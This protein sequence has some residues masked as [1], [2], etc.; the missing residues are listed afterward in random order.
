M[1]YAF[2]LN[3][4]NLLHLGLGFSHRDA[5]EVGQYGYSTRP[6]AHTAPKYLN[7][8]I[9]DVNSTQLLNSE[10]VFIH[11]NFMIESEYLL[12]HVDAASALNFAAYYGQI[13]YFFNNSYHHN[14]KGAYAGISEDV[15]KGALEIVARYSSAN[16]NDGSFVGGKINDI[17]FG[18]NYYLNQ[19]TRIMA[20][21]SFINLDGVGKATDLNL[22]FMTYF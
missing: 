3:Q 11:K 19:T 6:P 17:T 10:L 20:N 9:Q 18:L 16:L 22:R 21:Y 5:G 8:K 2:D 13:S 15:G 14:Y 12:A 1:T 4:D 7:V